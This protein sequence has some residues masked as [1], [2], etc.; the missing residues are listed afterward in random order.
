MYTTVPFERVLP[1]VT[2]WQLLYLYLCECVRETNLLWVWEEFLTSGLINEQQHIHCQVRPRNSFQHGKSFSK[3]DVCENHCQTHRK[4]IVWMPS[5]IHSINQ[6][7]TKVSVLKHRNESSK[8]TQTGNETKLLHMIN[9][10]VVIF[11]RS[12]EWVESWEQHTNEQTK[13]EY[14]SRCASDS[15]MLKMH[16]EQESL[17]P[18]I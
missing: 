18:K 14:L 7:E 1:Y 13:S 10:S 16:P 12:P 9:K 2:K 5:T 11:C 8:D 4:D 17:K 6:S 3:A 15:K